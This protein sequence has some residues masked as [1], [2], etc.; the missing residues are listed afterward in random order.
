MKKPSDDIPNIPISAGLHLVVGWDV[1]EAWFIQNGF[2]LLSVE[3]GDADGLHQPRVY[4]L[5]HSLQQD[6]RVMK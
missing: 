6:Q 1:S 3:V 2:N 5:F 4:Q